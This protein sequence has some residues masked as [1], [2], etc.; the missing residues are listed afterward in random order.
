MTDWLP[1]MKDL[2]PAIFGLLGAGVGAAAAMWGAHKAADA[3]LRQAERQEKHSD[4]QW[5][6]DQRQAA[7]VA[8]LQAVD[9][10]LLLEQEINE[11]RITNAQLPEG[12]T[13]R[14]VVLLSE[15]RSNTRMIDL[16]G[17]ESVRAAAEDLAKTTWDAIAVFSAGPQPDGQWTE[18][19]NVLRARDRA[20][21]VFRRA[22]AAALGFE[23]APTLPA[24]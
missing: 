6:R 15:I 19:L 24:A 2:L 17:P 22:A 1:D 14:I 23:S 5:V 3:A 7:V 18:V 13:D 10:A 9:R 11:A 21:N 8:V 16:T 12:A 20:H 4:R